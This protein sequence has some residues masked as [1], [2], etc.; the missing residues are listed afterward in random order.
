[1]SSNFRR[2][3]LRLPTSPASGKS[4][5]MQNVNRLQS[6]RFLTTVFSD[7]SIPLRRVLISNENLA[8]HP[9]WSPL[10]S[11]AYHSKPPSGLPVF[12]NLT[13]LRV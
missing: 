11:V 10:R 4:K 5:G 12:I 8:C 9:H 13:S 2:A 3:D 7:F 1:M 6:G